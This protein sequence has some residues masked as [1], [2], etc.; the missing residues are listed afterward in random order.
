M[1]KV[2][3]PE[4]CKVVEEG[5]NVTVYV[6]G[7]S[8]SGGVKNDNNRPASENKDKSEADKDWNWNKYGWG[9]DVWSSIIS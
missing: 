7:V 1:V 6:T 4:H 8:M 9:E 2:I 3:G 5:G